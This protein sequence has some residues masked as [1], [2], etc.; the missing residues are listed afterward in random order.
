MTIVEQQPQPQT[1]V[2][3]ATDSA[4][5]TAPASPDVPGGTTTPVATGDVGPRRRLHGATTIET[6]DLLGAGAAAI[7]TATLLFGKLTAMHGGIGW[8]VIALVTFVGFYALLVSLHS[9]AQDVKDKVATVLFRT[10]GVILFGALVFVVAY[11]VVRG[12]PALHHLNLFVETMRLAGPLDPLT[13][14]GVAH[15]MV[16]TL[17]QIS[18][19]LSI[20]IPLGVATAVFL[21]EVGGRFA[22]FVRTISDAMTA[23]P[24]VV[25]GLFVYAS[26]IQLF[27]HERSG[28]AASL[29]SGASDP[30]YSDVGI[31]LKD[32]F[33]PRWSWSLGASHAG[34]A[35]F[36][37]HTVS[38]TDPRDSKG[39]APG[40]GAPQS[41]DAK[42]GAS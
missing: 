13:V 8:V 10:A 11:T 12:T 6:F 25:A 18:I 3:A 33:A 34:N 14:G 7:A 2:R 26:V 20:T 16:G 17:I 5:S 30:S 36:Y 23:L 41:V 31:T 9:D 15:A 35:A 40:S 21:N 39:V 29:A 27:T 28:F 32:Q 24:S 22:R 1:P 4:E 37:A 38:F 19:A 42:A